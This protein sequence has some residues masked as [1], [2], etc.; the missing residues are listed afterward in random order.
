MEQRTLRLYPSEPVENNRLEQRI[1]KKLN[2]I[3]S[4]QSSISNIKE[5]TTYSKT[6]NSNPKR[7]IEHLKR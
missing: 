4:F 1:E 3:K 7:N 5:I 2:D 6:K